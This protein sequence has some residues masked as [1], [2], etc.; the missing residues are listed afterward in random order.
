MT[1]GTLSRRRLFGAATYAASLGG[2]SLLLPTP[3]PQLYRLTPK[4]S[5]APKPTRA[6]GELVVSTPM[7]SESLD[8][9]RIALTR[10]RITLDYFAGASWTD[11][12]PRMLQSLMIDAFEDSGRNIAV[13]RDSSDIGA[14]YR[15]ETVLRDFQA[16]YAG[17]GDSAP[18]V[19]VSVDA[20]L[21]RMTD[22][23]VVGHLLAT[24]EAP[25]ARNNLAS[26]VEAFDAV[27]GEV[28]DQ[29]VGWTLQSM[30]RV[31]GSRPSL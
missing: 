16:R 13:A 20:Q 23:R 4:T 14:D 28:I 1:S 29:I 8:T 12:A 18:I 21:L 27:V 10:N 31:R 15:L 22:R 6:S 25:A 7:A 24:K 5:D 19:V 9:E 11:R 2:C 3:A 26:I 17:T 30:A